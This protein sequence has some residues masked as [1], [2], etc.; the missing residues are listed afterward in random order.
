MEKHIIRQQLLARRRRLDE[1]ACRDLSLQIQQRLIDSD[2]FSRAAT[3]ALYSPVHNEVR[4]DRLL[5][6]AQTLGKRI[7]YPRVCGE[8]LRFVAIGS[9]ADLQSGTFGVAEPTSGPVLSVEQIDLIVVP[10]VA[11]DRSGFRLGYGKGFYDRELSRKGCD[12]I[13][14]GLCYGFQICPTLPIEAHDQALDFLAMETQLIPC[15]KDV[16]G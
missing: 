10:G 8:Q 7:C 5:R 9:A 2:C 3:L 11:F 4:T 6:V 14:V 15:H 12:A 1:A 13:S 16:A